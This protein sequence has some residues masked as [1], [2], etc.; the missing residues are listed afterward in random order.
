MTDYR[1]SEENFRDIESSLSHAQKLLANATPIEPPPETPLPVFLTWDD[2]QISGATIPGSLS[3]NV[4]QMIRTMVHRRSGREYAEFCNEVHRTTGS[5]ALMPHNF[6]GVYGRDLFQHPE[7][8]LRGAPSWFPRDLTLTPWFSAGIIDMQ[9]WVRQLID[10]LIFEP[11]FLVLDIEPTNRVLHHVSNA[12]HLFS[13][14]DK[15]PRWDGQPTLQDSDTTFAQLWA[16]SGF[17]F[18][19]WSDYTALGANKAWLHWW[20]VIVWQEM[21]AVKWI[22]YRMLREAFPNIICCDWLDF[23]TNNWEG[24]GV[25]CL[26]TGCPYNIDTPVFYAPA[27]TERYL[28]ERK[29]AVFTGRRT[30]PWV[31]TDKDQRRQIEACHELGMSCPVVILWN[32]HRVAN[33]TRRRWLETTYATIA[34]VWGL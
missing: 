16:E 32:D 2:P 3:G 31:R 5:T 9:E 18:T 25:K 17:Q 7:D 34:D 28:T 20:E 26:A 29:E 10:G 4:M 23:E 11:R 19:P 14:I 33:E 24:W 27:P 6:G 1:I 13:T 22:A 8:A 30:I 15:D 12:V 21:N